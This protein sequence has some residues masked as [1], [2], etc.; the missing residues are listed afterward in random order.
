M[1]TFGV[2]FVV[3]FGVVFM[4]IFGVVFLIIFPLCRAPVVIHVTTVAT[5]VIVT[6]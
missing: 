1:V 3:I 2:V 6:G 5:V 4:L